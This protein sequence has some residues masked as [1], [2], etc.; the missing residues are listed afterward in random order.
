MTEVY[1]PIA[2]KIHSFGLMRLLDP[3][4][5]GIELYDRWKRYYRGREKKLLFFK[6]HKNGL[7]YQL[8]LWLFEDLLKHDY[9]I[10]KLKGEYLFWFIED[11]LELLQYHSLS[12]ES[13]LL[14]EVSDDVLK[15]SSLYDEDENKFFD[16]VSSRKFRRRF[17]KH[18][19]KLSEIFAGEM[20]KLAP[21]Y[22]VNYSNRVFHDR[23]LC[24]YIADLLV[25]IGFD[26][27]V[28]DDE[29]PKK[30]VKRL[31]I[32]NWVKRI[33]IA[34]DRGKCSLCEKNITM[35][36]EEGSHFDHIVPLSKGGFNDILN[37]QL[38]CKI[39]NLQK[40]NNL[41]TVKSSIP[42]YFRTRKK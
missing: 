3:N 42:P 15:V 13:P 7:L 6:F 22:A 30:W 20:E 9:Y 4:W 12:N 29:E 24:N 31:E 14:K 21:N 8:G 23:E 19:K 11:F 25:K 28:E 38:L 10:V 32:P 36:L 2:F 5:T 35:E 37:I 34:R 33:V 26:G 39:C 1:L 17:L 27:T 40:K 16:L 18:H 41:I